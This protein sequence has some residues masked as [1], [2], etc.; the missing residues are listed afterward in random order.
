M[1][2]RTI[3]TVAALRRTVAED[4]AEG[5]TIGLV[6]TMG[7]LHDG[8]LSLVRRARAESGTVVLSLFVNPTQFDSGE[9]LAAYP[10]DEARDARLAAEAGVD[11]LF[12]P[13]ATE[14]YPAGFAT[15]VTVSGLTD[16][17]CGRERGPGH[18]A[19]VATVVTKL[20]NMVAPDVAYFG[21]KDAQQVAVVRRLVRDL[22]I[23]VR[24]EVCPT[25]READGLAMSS[26]NA[27]L[28]PAERARAVG[29]SRALRAAQEAA[30]GG[31][32]DPRELARVARAELVEHEIEPEYVEVV[33]P[34][35][36]AP[37]VGAGAG[38]G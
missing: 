17:L 3:T 9:D 26:R 25:V 28:N 18:F 10:R 20:L 12:A 6:A 36:M 33:S 8:H 4:R 1:T 23:P 24:I 16:G 38:A 27:R 19:G 30:S 31:E 2:L 34:E 7:A 29:L 21:Q 22:D 15:T 14:V 37:P 35:T 5:R 32:R 13:P 11:I